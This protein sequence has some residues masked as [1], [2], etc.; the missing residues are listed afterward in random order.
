VV[1]G[2]RLNDAEQPA[3]LRWRG[4]GRPLDRLFRNDLAD[5]KPRFTDV[6]E[7]SGIH[8]FGYGMGVAAGDY[9]NDG[10]VDLYVTNLGSNYLLRNNGDG[11]FDDVA[12]KARCDDG[13]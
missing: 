9:N 11:T 13:R 7:A 4:E 5:G 3:G 8:A 2:A 6:T 1:Q 12:A 10:W